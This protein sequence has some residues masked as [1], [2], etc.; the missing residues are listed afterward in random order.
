MTTVRL[1]TKE[2]CHLCDD[3]RVVLERVR[4]DIPFSLEEVHIREGDGAFTAYHELI[5]VVTVNDTVAFKYRVNEGRF[6]ALLATAE[7]Q[8]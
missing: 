2:G 4:K 1:Y 7:S 3:A 8:Q 6:R 5:P